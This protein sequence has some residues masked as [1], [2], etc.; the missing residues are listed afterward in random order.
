M[1][2]NS[3]MCAHF[4]D[5]VIR[6]DKRLS[7]KLSPR[8]LYEVVCIS[9]LQIIVGNLISLFAG[10]L[11]LVPESRTRSPIC[12]PIPGGRHKLSRP[13]EPNT[14]WFFFRK[15]V[16]PGL[17]IEWCTQ[18]FSRDFLLSCGYLFH[19]LSLSFW[20]SKP[21]YYSLCHNL[22]VPSLLL[23]CISWVDYITVDK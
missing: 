9:K 22:M 1:G 11:I 4:S 14:C 2:R 7:K 3:T 18:T 20:P 6:K 12:W 13:A 16:Y 19:C 17:C 5:P 23:A 8:L 10:S 15:G 21:H